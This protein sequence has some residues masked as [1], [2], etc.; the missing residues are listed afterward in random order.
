MPFLMWLVILSDRDAHFWWLAETQ[1]LI[2]TVGCL[3][4]PKRGIVHFY[5]AGVTDAILSLSLSLCVCVCVEEAVV[6]SD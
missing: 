1:W 6:G 4:Y 3:C 2:M 5:A